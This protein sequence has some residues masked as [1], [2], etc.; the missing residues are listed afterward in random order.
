MLYDDEFYHTIRDGSSKS[1]AVVV[2]LIVEMLRPSSVV[3]VGCGTGS[4]LAQFREEGVEDILGL[5]YSE[6]S[7][8]LLQVD[9]GVI[10]HV[11]L[12][13]PFALERA[14]DV[15]ISLEV[16]EHLPE[17]SAATFV[18]SLSQLAPVVVFSAA[19]PGQG[20]IGH[21]NEQWPSFWVRYFAE[22][23]Y[24]VVDCLRDQ[25]WRDERIEWWYRQNLL[26]FV[27][28]DLLERFVGGGNG[29]AEKVLDRMM[30]LTS[31]IASPQQERPVR[32]STLGVIVLTKNGA[33]R[34]EQCL[35]SV[36]ASA[37]PDELHVFVDRDTTDCTME[38]AHRFTSS[39]QTIE[40]KGNIESVLSEMAAHCSSDYIL[41]VDDDE[42][43][44]GNWNRQ[45]LDS[46]LRPNDFTYLLVPRR[47]LAPPG[48][49]FIANEPWFPDLKLRLFRNDT[50]LV[51]WPN[52]IHEPIRVRGRGLISFDQWIDHSCLVTMSRPE[53][54][55][56][57]RENQRVRPERHQSHFY[58]YEEQRINLVSLSRVDY[59]RAVQSCIFSESSTYEPGSAIEF[60]VGGNSESYT[61][62]GWSSP[63]AW[64][65]WTTGC[66]AEI[67]LPLERYFEGP[68]ILSVVAG[69]YLND[70]HRT[71]EVQVLCG[72][73]VIGEWAIDTTETVQR[74][75]AIPEELVAYKSRLVLTFCVKNP[76]APSESGQSTDSRLLGLGFRQL[77][78]QQESS[79][80]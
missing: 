64:G 11:D 74:S 71:V 76:S 54:E 63:E 72:S 9:E 4:W 1:A 10:R 73:E 56:K 47:W 61:R 32:T 46:L 7:T 22:N 3:D 75:I 77:Y 8:H 33:G 37:A 36:I 66:H 12:C 69:A 44:G 60:S 43:L 49:V 28:N 45:D 67:H 55:N 23:G 2:P 41:R 31:R 16:A 14:F 5:D 78:L 48:D 21:L 58:L 13:A 39:V 30:P 38:V 17:G 42:S 26:V 24:A 35:R 6:C 80:N 62:E 19:I 79:L 57:C 34:I 20:G 29:G 59:R 65:R 25:I 27:R 51:E 68:A 52:L 50:K 18:R 53:R 15:A 40:T 70:R